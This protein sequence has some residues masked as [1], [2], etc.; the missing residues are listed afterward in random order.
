[1]KKTNKK[2]NIFPIIILA[3]AL[4]FIIIVFIILFFNNKTTISE[5]NDS[6]SKKDVI[7]CSSDKNVEGVYYQGDASD[8]SHSVKLMVNGKQI[9]SL[10]YEY[11]ASFPS[12]LASEDVVANMNA[13]YNI[14]LRDNGVSDKP[15]SHFNFNGKKVSI[16]LRAKPQQINVYSGKYFLLDDY[17]ANNF[18]VRNGN[19][20]RDYYKNLG[21]SCESK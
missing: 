16:T 10:F 5:G 3:I 6:S 4:L 20:V 2:Y 9:E 21:F 14:F 1:M 8:V 12:S 15:E 18:S 19:E 13:D 17:L 7:I 11:K